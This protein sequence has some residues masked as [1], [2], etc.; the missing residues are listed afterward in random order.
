MTDEIE[1]R[2]DAVPGTEILVDQSNGNKSTSDF[3]RYQHVIRGDARILLVLQP[4]LTDPN[5]PIRWPKWKKRLVFGMV[6]CT[7]LWE[8]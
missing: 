8:L 7:P 4:S 3:E 5:D 1:S 2:Y 6:C